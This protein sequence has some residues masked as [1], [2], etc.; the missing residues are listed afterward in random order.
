MTRPPSQRRVPGGTVAAGPDRELEVVLTGEADRR[1]DV[2]DRPRPDDDGRPAIVDGV[3]QPTRLVVVAVGRRDDVATSGLPEPPQL[4]VGEP[5]SRLD[6]RR[7][8]LPRHRAPT[9]QSGAPVARGYL[10]RGGARRA[11]RRIGTPGTPLRRRRTTV[12]S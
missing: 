2:G 9:R 3:P 4:G 8:V 5:G 12:W 10:S 6:H 7:S 1:R 11:A